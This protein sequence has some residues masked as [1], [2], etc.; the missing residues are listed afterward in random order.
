[1]A[2]YASFAAFYDAV[3]GDRAEHADYVCSLL[4]RERPDARRILELACG[5]GSVLSRLRDRYEVVGVDLSP[6][7]LAVAAAKLP[8]VRLV[9]DDM[10]RVRLGETF[11]AVICLYDSINH[12]LRWPDWEALF[13][14]ACAH[15]DAR[16]VLVFDVNT[17]QRLALLATQPPIVHRFDGNVL[18]LDVVGVGDG[19]VDWE[20]NV[21]EALGDRMYRLHEETVPELGVPTERIREALA[22]RFQRV[23]VVDP[24][25]SR[26]TSRSGR[27]WFVARG[28]RDA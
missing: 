27:L 20:L 5:T 25:R 2:G 7:M 24:Q 6:E 23:R 1:M 4:E 19:T 13:D 28:R 12:L 10:T 14:T 22:V 15:L 11:D 21:F 9:E 26:P 18:L 16:G 8:D 3:Q 17:P